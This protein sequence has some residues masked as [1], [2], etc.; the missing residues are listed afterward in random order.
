MAKTCFRRFISVSKSSQVDE[1][2]YALKISVFRIEDTN[3]LIF[4]AYKYSS[5]WLDFD[6]EI[7]RLKQVFANNS[8]PQNL[9]ESIINDLLSKHHRGIIDTTRESIPHIDYYVHLQ[10]LSTFKIDT[11]Q[12]KT[13][14]NTH[15]KPLGVEAISVKTYFKSLKY[16]IENFIIDYYD[17][18][19]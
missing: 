12:I 17:K 7:N 15:C 1:Y 5:T 8:Y 18:K 2:L 16:L 6:T 4:R 14:I 9:T 13:I 11:K 3:T 10:N 19:T